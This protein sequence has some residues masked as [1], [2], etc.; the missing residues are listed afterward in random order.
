MILGEEIV[1]EGTIRLGANVIIGYLP[2]HVEYPDEEQTVLEYFARL[3]D[4][5][6][7]A[8]RSQL[9]K[10]LFLQ[11]DVN[12]KIKYLSGGEKSRLRLCSLTFEGANL[13]ILDEPTNHLDV[14]SREVLEET[15]N[16]FEGTLLFVSHDRY[17]I[18]KLAD[19]VIII[20]GRTIHEYDGDYAYYQDEHK[21]ELDRKSAHLVKN[22]SGTQIRQGHQTASKD[23]VKNVIEGGQTSASKFNS[24][25]S[26]DRG[27]KKP[28]RMLEQL[29]YTIEALEDKLKVLQDMM[30]IH[31]TDGTRLA[32]LFAE[33][34]MLEAELEIAYLEWEQLQT[35]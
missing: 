17:F 33:N 28:A 20:E 22:S 4:L 29:E 25:N 18:N 5:T 2:Q 15:L 21:K 16:E 12:K 14:D 13:L 8:A 30:E 23:K 7:G 24:N 11:E 31:N 34:K 10:V 32:E 1:E 9:A 27:I 3:H 6:N 26:T 19:K 35:N